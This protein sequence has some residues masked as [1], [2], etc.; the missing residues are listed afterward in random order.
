[1]GP[2]GR[3]RQDSA[4]FGPYF[5]DMDLTQTTM[6]TVLRFLL[7][8]KGFGLCGLWRRNIFAGA[9][10][11]LTANEPRFAAQGSRGQR[12]LPRFCASRRMT[13]WGGGPWEVFEVRGA[14]FGR[15]RG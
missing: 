11:G 9:R 5:N 10:G 2:F 6:P 1:M 8:W 14:G 7:G 15:E 13:A 3:G 4:F 12:Q